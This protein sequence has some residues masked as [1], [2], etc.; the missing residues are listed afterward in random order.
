[1]QRRTLLRWGLVGGAVL[2]VAGTGASF[3]HA[4]AWRDGTL[5]PAGRQVLGAIARAV[6]DGSLPQDNQSGRVAM[7]AHLG[8]IQETIAAMTPATQQELALLLALLSSVAG[9]WALAGLE[10]HWET[11][12][13]AAVQS[14]LQSMRTSALLVRR[15]AYHALRDLTHA[16]YFADRQTWGRLH[17]PGPRDLGASTS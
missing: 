12:T 8:R 11:A 17:Y 15:Q 6:L 14:S 9:R 16:A 2:V 13:V 7:E 3:I 5:Q 1:M 4:P 10:E